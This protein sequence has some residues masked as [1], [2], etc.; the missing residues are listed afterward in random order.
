MHLGQPICKSGPQQA[1]DSIHHCL[2]LWWSKLE[3]FLNDY[4]ARRSGRETELASSVEVGAT[5][6]STVNDKKECG[7]SK[8]EIDNK[9]EDIQLDMEEVGESRFF[10]SLDSASVI[11]I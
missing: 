3:N 4:S 8:E 9:D 1:R 11:L 5:G 10:A 6:D 7:N 2:N